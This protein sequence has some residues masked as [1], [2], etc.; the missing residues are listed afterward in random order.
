[1]ITGA[2]M[3]STVGFDD[4]PRFDTSKVYYIG[5]YWMLASEA[6][7]ELVLPEHIPKEPL[8][9]RRV[10]TQTASASDHPGTASHYPE[11]PSA[12][13]KL[14]KLCDRRKSGEPPP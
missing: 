14:L 2:A 7:A 3:L 9:F 4:E 1:M 5:R 11:S 12:A 8:R 13:K 6:P 10:P